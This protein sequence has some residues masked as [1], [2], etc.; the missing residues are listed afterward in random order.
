LPIT[1]AQILFEEKNFPATNAASCCKFPQIDS[2]GATS[3]SKASFK[4]TRRG[5]IKGK[6]TSSKD[7]PKSTYETKEQKEEKRRFCNNVRER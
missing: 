3:V 4:I 6:R 2:D 1:E 5:C 7:Q